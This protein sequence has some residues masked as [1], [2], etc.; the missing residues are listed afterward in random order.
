[1]PVNQH[2][3]V[4]NLGFSCPRADVS[5]QSFMVLSQN[6]VASSGKDDQTRQKIL[7]YNED[8]CRA[9]MH[10]FD[11]P[12]ANAAVKRPNEKAHWKRQKGES[13]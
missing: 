12:L 13:P 9:I 1:M 11:W 7:D 10:L 6:Y 4:S 8:D 2:L 5:G 3:N